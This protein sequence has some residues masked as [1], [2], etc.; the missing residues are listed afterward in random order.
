MAMSDAIP[1]SD[2]DAWKL[3]DGE[4]ED[5]KSLRC[6]L[7]GRIIPWGGTKYYLMNTRRYCEDCIED[8]ADWND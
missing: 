2:Y 7:C 4:R 8:H 1:M 6:D 3:M 5:R